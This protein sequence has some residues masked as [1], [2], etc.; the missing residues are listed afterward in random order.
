M[1]E[2]PDQLDVEAT[3]VALDRVVRRLRVG[4]ALAWLAV[5]TLAATVVVAVL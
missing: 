3:L 1:T 4:L 2:K 5:A